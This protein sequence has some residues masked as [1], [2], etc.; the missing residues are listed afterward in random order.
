MTFTA[1]S[2]FTTLSFRKLFLVRILLPKVSKMGKIVL[3]IFVFLSYTNLFAQGEAAV[4]TLLLQ[5]SI[6]LY[7]AGQIGAAI[8]T[9]DPTGF[10]F[11]PANLGLASQNNHVSSSFMPEKA[12]W[13]NV[14]NSNTTFSTYGFN[15]GYNFQKKFHK[16]PISVGLGYIHNIFDLGKQYRDNSNREE[17]YLGN[18]KDSFKS[19]SV[20]IG[21][22][23][24]LMFNFGIS[25]KSFNS[26]LLANY[27]IFTGKP[28]VI[29][30]NGTA[31]DYGIMIIA[32]ISQLL[33]NNA[34]YYLH[35]KAFIKPKAN[36]TLGY[37]L[38]N[39]GD[40]IYFSDKAQSDPIPRTARFGY[41]LDLGLD[42]FV[43]GQKINAINYS[44]TAE[45]EDILINNNLNGFEYQGAF[46]DIKLGKNLVELK[47]DEDVTV[48][49]GHIF[50]FFE[51]LI[52]ET[53]RFDG[54]GFSAEGNNRKANGFGLSS[55]GILKLLSATINNPI[56]SF[57]SHHFVAEYF[58]STLFTDS[59]LETNLKGINLNFKNID[60]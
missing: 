56:L 2:I 19:F 48:R 33:L 47:G 38:T 18:P 41:T 59:P 37:S 51:T 20:G 42:L 49:R 55:E 36:F 25:F 39:V 53:G 57:V 6:S 45:A 10:Y 32:P 60:F 11:N 52:L 44:F 50:K 15:I 30:A 27:N 1:I 29:E 40:E 54:H 21:V 14:L 13:L 34:N 26:Q 23:Y 7:G 4:P 5:Q 58:S 8:P 3:S 9:N 28:K 43:K 16:I 31:K 12:N 35:S 46:G 22:N 24:Y 17:D